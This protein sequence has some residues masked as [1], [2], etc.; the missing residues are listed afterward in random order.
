MFEVIKTE[1]AVYN[2]F[3]LLGKKWMLPILINFWKNPEYTLKF[4]YLSRALPTITSRVI[5]MRLKELEFGGVI[6]K[7]LIEGKNYYKLT[8]HG[9]NLSKVFNELVIWTHEAGA[10]DCNGNCVMC[11]QLDLN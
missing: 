5:S 3:D 9:K 1:C 4:S 7:V 2:N 8:V 10:C 11:T 6:E